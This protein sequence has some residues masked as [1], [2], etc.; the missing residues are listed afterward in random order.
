MKHTIFSLFLFLFIIPLHLFAQVTPF[1]STE[2][3]GSNN[4]EAR[5]AVDLMDEEWRSA[6]IIAGAC[7]EDD[8][9]I[10]LDLTGTIAVANEVEF[11]I[12]TTNITIS[13]R[14]MDG[15]VLG[16]PGTDVSLDTSSTLQG[17]AIR[18]SS[19]YNAGAQPEFLNEIM[20]TAISG[21][22]KNALLISFDTPVRSFGAWFGDLETNSFGVNAELQFFDSSNNQ[23]GSTTIIPASQ[24]WLIEEGLVDLRG[25]PDESLC[26]GG[27]EACGN[28]TTRWVGFVSDE[29]NP[30]S[31][32]LVVVGDEDNGDD[33][34]TEHISLIGPTL[35]TDF[36]CGEV[37]LQAV[38]IA[39]D[40]EISDGD[41][42]T[43]NILISNQG[44]ADATN[45][46]VTDT[47]PTNVDFVSAISSDGSLCNHA[48]GVVTCAIP[49]ILVSQDSVEIEI[50][51]TPTGGAGNY[52]NSVS[53]DSDGTD[54][55][56]SNNTD[57]TSFLV[58][59]IE[60]TTVTR[61]QICVTNDFV[62]NNSAVDTSARAL[63]DGVL[64]SI[65]LIRRRARAGTCQSSTTSNLN[66]IRGES[67]A[68]YTEI[69]EAVWTELPSANFSCDGTAPAECSSFDS[70]T[71]LSNTQEN[72]TTLLNSAV[73]LLGK[74]CVRDTAKAR[75]ILSQ[76]NTSLSQIQ[77]ELSRYPSTILSC[78]FE[79]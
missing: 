49:S 34:F 47:L 26:G 41:N 73:E 9:I 65:Q 53:V 61:P 3:G 43:F 69:W 60:P 5:F 31:H 45:V 28:Q 4:A 52:T 15:P 10:T 33:G 20:N 1:I 19:L 35:A 67:E 74:R 63:A 32:M 48:G 78:S 23:I 51:I 72:A 50:T 16:S 25:A 24:D 37:D 27:I 17:N 70:S 44:P 71:I 29:N 58:T 42:A 36:S 21:M 14:N 79:F 8:D 64:R 6:S 46:V 75:K 59:V 57:T 66:L 76:M 39:S 13:N 38:K 2:I 56:L 18:P 62:Q 30:V 11:T 68:L 12:G 77:S 22:S 40:S 7:P 55:N 54:S